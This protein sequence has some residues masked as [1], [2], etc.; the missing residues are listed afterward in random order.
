[1][2]IIVGNLRVVVFDMS[3]KLVKI[4]ETDVAATETMPEVGFQSR[5]I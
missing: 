1:M 4:V 2:R 3:C 5:Q